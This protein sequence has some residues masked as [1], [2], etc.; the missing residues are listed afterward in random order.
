MKVAPSSLL[1]F[2]LC[3]FSYSQ[4]LLAHVDDSFLADLA[5]NAKTYSAVCRYVVDGDSLYLGGIKKQ[6]RLWGVDAP[7]RD[8][9]GY[10]EATR[11][12]RILVDSKPIQCVQKDVDKYGRIVARCFVRADGSDFWNDVNQT[13]IEE[14]TAEEYCRFSRG[15]YG[16]CED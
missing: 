11:A 2:L 10:Q 14:G 5:K 1:L 3:H 12:L 16:H 9:D 7:E 8:E 13:M 6:I 4:M 15:F